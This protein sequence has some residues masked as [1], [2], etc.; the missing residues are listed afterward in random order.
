MYINIYSII[1]ILIYI[2]YS[3]EQGNPSHPRVAGYSSHR[4]YL[5]NYCKIRKTDCTIEKNNSFYISDQSFIKFTRRLMYFHNIWIK[6]IILDPCK[7]F[8]SQ[9]HF[10]AVYSLEDKV[11]IRFA[12]KFDSYVLQYMSLC[13]RNFNTKKK[14]VRKL[15]AMAWVPAVA[16]LI[17]MNAG[18]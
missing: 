5:K 8:F 2:V 4:E 10:P 7:V 9:N 18:N 13:M 11:T 17:F 15:L 14:I 6:V 1:S 16:C 3:V 12:S